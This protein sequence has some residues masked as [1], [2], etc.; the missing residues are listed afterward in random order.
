[1][2]I[3]TTY[4]NATGFVFQHF[5][6]TQNFKIYEIDDGKI[7]NSEVIDNG[8]FGHHDLATYLK[9]LGV[10]I[11]ILGNRGQGAVDALNKAGLKQFAGV[12]GSADK[13]VEDYLLGTLKFN[14]E[15]MC[16]HN[17]HHEHN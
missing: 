15:A 1:M 6:K 13:A 2:K 7:T 3:A 4:D 12:K 8:G 5:G 14:N 10:E 11:L 9:N 17:H 16:Q